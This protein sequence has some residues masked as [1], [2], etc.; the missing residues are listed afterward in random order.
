MTEAPQPAELR[1][2]AP[3]WTLVEWAALGLLAALAVALRLHG[4]GAEGFADDEIH[5]WLAASRYLHGDFGGDD[6]EH[7]ML[8]KGLIALCIAALRGHASP[9]ALTRLPNVLAAA[10]TVFAVAFAGRRL[11]GK[12]VGVLASAIY[13]VAAVSVGY[14]RIAKED[15]LFTLFFVLVI[16]CVAEAKAAADV[17]DARAQARWELLGAAALGASFASKYFVFVIV[18]MPVLYA[19][20]RPGSA[21][22]APFSRWVK[23]SLV[24]LAVMLSLDWVVLTRPAWTYIAHYLA[25]GQDLGDRGTSESYLFMG[26]LWDNL[27]FHIGAAAPWWFHLAFAAVKFTPLV[28]VL[29]FFGLALAFWRRAPSDRVVLAWIFFMLLVFFVSGAKYGRY[30]TCI[31]PAFACAAAEAAR[32][33]ANRLRGPMARAGAFAALAVLMLG[34]EAWATVTHL[35]HP[36]LYVNALAGGDAKLDYWFP[37]CDYFDA[38]VREA[39][40]AIAARAEPGAELS[41]ETG[42]VIRYYLDQAGRSD[43]VNTPF[44]PGK[45]C[46]KGRVCYVLTQSGRLYWHNQAAMAEL[47]RQQPWATF[48]VGGHPAVRVYRLEPGAPL[49]PAGAAAAAAR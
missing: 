37:H 45:A 29:M 17:G 12:S 38:G 21:W 16:A 6:L 1:G 9:E 32:Q 34:N 39:V 27:A 11:Y 33:L 4:L 2:P 15:T 14:G 13:A 22:R 25:G 41:G 3:R 30:F 36:R 46:V 28:A 5:K 31:L 24:A 8:M 10:P 43:V 23:L 49:F 19:V 18:L 26:K 42:W 7:P 48:E 35:P 40:Q 47:A 44:M 20:L